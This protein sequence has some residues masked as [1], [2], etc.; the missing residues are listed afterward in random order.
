MWKY[1]NHKEKHCMI[2]A[3]NLF[4]HFIYFVFLNEIA[5]PSHLSKIVIARSNPIQ[6]KNVCPH[7]CPPPWCYWSWNGLSRH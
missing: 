4:P 1:K 3:L 5:D 2:S 7:F 6:D